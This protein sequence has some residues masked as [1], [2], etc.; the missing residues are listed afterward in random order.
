[1][2]KVDIEKILELV[3]QSTTKGS[4]WW[5]S[6]YTVEASQAEICELTPLLVD[7]FVDERVRATAE[8]IAAMRNNIVPICEELKAAREVVEQAMLESESYPPSEPMSRF[9]DRYTEVTK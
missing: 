7:E 2:S 4:K 1:M 9:L 8:L 3:S 5:V 6:G